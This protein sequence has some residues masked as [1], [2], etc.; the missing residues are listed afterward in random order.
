MNL[1]KILI[2]AFISFL[3]A[4]GIGILYLGLR[5][6]VRPFMDAEGNELPESIA[7]LEKL[8]I[9]GTNQWISIRGRDRANPVL[10][11]L[12]GGPGSAQMSMS[13]YLDAE[14]EEEYVVVHWDQRGAGKSNYSGFSE[15]T[16]T[17]QQFKDDT[18]LLISFLQESLG[19]EK[20]YLLGHSWGTQL[21]IELV[22][23]YPEKFHAYIA[24]SQVVDHTRAVEIAG[25]WLRQEMKEGGDQGGLEK[26]NK[27]DNPAY[28]HKDYRE[29][30]QLTVSYGGN[31]DKSFLELA[32]ISFKAPEYTFIDYYRL[33]DGMRRGGAPIHQD[34][35]MTQFNYIDSIPEIEV[36]IYFL[37]GS[38]DYNTPLQLVEEYY[39]Q[40]EAPAKK[41]IVFE[42]SAHTPFISETERFNDEIISILHS[43]R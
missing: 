1:S 2:I 4:I 14:L 33:L 31:Y 23:E 16:M 41:M 8:K 38:Y 11:W 27:I 32:L 26:L 5:P 7:V 9:N 15:E 30:A 35:I 13:H 10:L 22:D 34:G 20:I 19:Q 21:G 42:D 39:N 18:L 25:D 17:I 36:P 37:V 43:D 28:Y 12:H 24:V 40:I 29:L 3:I 6:S